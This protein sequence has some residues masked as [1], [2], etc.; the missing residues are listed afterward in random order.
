MANENLLGRAKVGMLEFRKQLAHELIHSEH[1]EAESSGEKQC[2][3][4]RHKGRTMQHEKLSVP[5][6]QKLRGS[7]LV[8]SKTK[9]NQTKCAGCKKRVR[10]HCK[11]SP[12]ATRC[13][14]CCT[15]HVAVEENRVAG[16]C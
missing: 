8:P 9:H 15:S 16:W 3:S 7:E 5:V 12:G 10:T 1:F 11:C 2:E 6:G 4:P 13:D 14:E